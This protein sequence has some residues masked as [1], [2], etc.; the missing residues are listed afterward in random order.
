MGLDWATLSTPV[1]IALVPIL[2]MLIKKLIPDRLTWLIPL[3][4][5]ALGPVLDFLQS[6]FTTVAPTSARAIGLGLAGIG[7]REL[8]DQIRKAMV[9]R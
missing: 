9:P 1:I 6:T 4:A 8:I 5:T 7:I 3:I 2:V